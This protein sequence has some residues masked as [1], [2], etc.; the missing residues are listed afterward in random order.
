MIKLRNIAQYPP[1]HSKWSSFHSI[2][3]TVNRKTV[4]LRL[5][6]SKFNLFSTF[7]LSYGKH[8]FNMTPIYHFSTHGST[9]PL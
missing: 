5:A 3:F 4:P 8:M 9:S 1:L 7:Q 2:V 6:V